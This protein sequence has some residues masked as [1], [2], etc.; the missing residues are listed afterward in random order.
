MWQTDRRTLNLGFCHLIKLLFLLFYVFPSNYDQ[1]CDYSSDWHAL[2]FL[3]VFLHLLKAFWRQNGTSGLLLFHRRIS[4]IICPSEDLL[5]IDTFRRLSRCQHSGVT[6]HYSPNIASGIHVSEPIYRCVCRYGLQA[7]LMWGQPTFLRQAIRGRYLCP[8]SRRVFLMVILVPVAR[9]P[10]VVWG[11]W[12]ESAI[13]DTGVAFK[14]F[15]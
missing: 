8:W 12:R 5:R 13:I 7:G 14:C 6:D 10:R 1:L 2:H 11:C 15:P 3:P 9:E 4:D